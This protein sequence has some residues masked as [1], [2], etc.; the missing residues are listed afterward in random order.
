LDTAHQ[1]QDSPEM[2]ADLVRLV[3][4]FGP[5][6]GRLDTLAGNHF[7]PPLRFRYSS[8]A[9]FASWA[10]LNSSLAACILSLRC[11]SI[12]SSKRTN[13]V[14]LATASMSCFSVVFLRAIVVT[15]W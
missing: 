13:L 12:G 7:A 9:S 1:V 14:S 4:I 2:L 3:R 5:V 15:P 6:P 11:I 8:T 10:M